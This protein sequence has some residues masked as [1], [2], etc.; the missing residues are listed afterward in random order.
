MKILVNATTSFSGGGVQ[1]GVAFINYIINENIAFDFICVITKPIFENLPDNIRND[2]RLI[3]FHHSPALI[4]KGNYVRR[5]LLKLEKRYRPDLIYSLSFPSYVKFQTKEIGRYTNPW[6][7]FSAKLAWST[8]SID[9]KFIRRVKN[10]YRLFWAKR[11]SYFET[12]TEYAK[13]KI[14]EKF[15]INE[16]KVKV[17]SNSI[18]PIFIGEKTDNKYYNKNKVK[19]FCLAAD[20]PHKN[21]II[22]PEV[23]SIIKR[24][25]DKNIKFILT[26]PIKSNTWSKIKTKAE[27]YSISNNIINLEP[28]SLK[29]CLEWYNKIDFVF[30]PTLLE[31]FSANY[32]EAMM[33]KKLIITSNLPFAKE[34]CGEGAIYFKANNAEAAARAIINAV[35]DPNRCNS[36][37][38]IASKQLSCFPSFSKKHKI[39]TDWISSIV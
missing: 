38:K 16:K 4:F 39:V 17:V 30:Q 23:A 36:I 3:V 10:I 5:E 18:N 29:Q 8:L 34:V 15:S 31:V 27:K 2:N 24:N 12:Q 21:L 1:V 26:L 32:L 35:N 33:M 11:A 19:I 37:I 9:Q 22:I 20:Y 14:I 25:C 13:Q 7:I 6:E 28:I